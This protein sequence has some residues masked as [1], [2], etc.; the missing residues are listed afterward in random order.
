MKCICGHMPDNHY[1]KTNCCDGVALPCCPCSHYRPAPAYWPEAQALL[2]AFETA[3]RCNKQ[4]AA[5][6]DVVRAAHMDLVKV[7]L[8]PKGLAL[9]E[10]VAL[11]GALRDLS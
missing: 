9:G 6:N 1:S 3:E 5:A 8:L 11:V 2:D 10:V 4:A 7:L